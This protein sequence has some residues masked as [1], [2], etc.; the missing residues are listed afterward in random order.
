MTSNLRK[1]MRDGDAFYL[2]AFFE[3]D[4]YYYFN[5][6]DAKQLYFDFDYNDLTI[7]YGD[8]R[9]SEYNINSDKTYGDQTND[10]L[11]G[12]AFIGGSGQ[13]VLRIEINPEEDTFNYETSFTNGGDF[14]Y[15]IIAEDE[16]G[17]TATMKGNI[18]IKDIEP[19]SFSTSYIVKNFLRSTLSEEIKNEILLSRPFAPGATD[20][21]DNTPTVT[22]EVLLE[23]EYPRNPLV[24]EGYF[25]KYIAEDS[26]GNKTESN[27]V[28]IIPHNIQLEVPDEVLQVEAFLDEEQLKQKLIE[29]ITINY[30]GFPAEKLQSTPFIEVYE[31]AE[32][33]NP[34]EAYR[35]LGFGDT[36]TFHYALIYAAKGISN[37]DPDAAIDSFFDGHEDDRLVTRT[38]KYTMDL[39]SLYQMNHWILNGEELINWMM[40]ELN[41]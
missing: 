4:E 31:I 20:N 23:T 32:Q 26:A 1:T 13:V 34:Y 36:F 35:Q 6:A 22:Y 16:Y 38:V 9:L 18:K 12:V 17:N 28:E 2:V 37:S 21:I 3:I 15:T 10:L 39:E 27:T 8:D 30:N 19:P 29:G 24:T 5:P 33:R 11:Q 25:I 41:Y 14:T 7:S 40:L